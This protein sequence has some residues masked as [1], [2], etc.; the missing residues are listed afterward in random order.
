MD[1][2][3]FESIVMLMQSLLLTAQTHTHTAATCIW[4]DV[5]AASRG[6]LLHSG[7]K[8]ANVGNDTCSTAKI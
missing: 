8:H 4:W 1:A 7:F 6:L 5:G 3:D 2:N